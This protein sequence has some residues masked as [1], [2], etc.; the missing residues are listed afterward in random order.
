MTTK[1]ADG[2]LLSDD[3]AF[4]YFSTERFI[5]D[6]CNGSCCFICG[7][8]PNLKQFN[9]EHV[10]PR[11]LLK[12]YQLFERSIALPNGTNFRYRSYTV[13]CCR[14]CN[15][16]MGRDIEEPIRRILNGSLESLIE[17]IEREGVR[18]LF[19]WLCLI[20]IK[21]HLKS[22]TLPVERDRRKE[23]SLIG[24]QYDWTLLHHIHCVARSFYTRA[25][26]DQNVFGSLLIFQAKTGSSYEPFDYYDIYGANSILVRVGNFSLVS[27]LDDAGGSLDMFR[28]HIDIINGPL[29]PI[30]LREILA[31]LSYINLHI[32]ERPA[33]FTELRKP[34]RIRARVPV[35]EL[36]DLDK[37]HRGQLLDACCG[38]M[39][40]NFTNSNI[41]EVKLHLLQGTHTFLRNEYGDFD[42]RSMEPIE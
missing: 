8:S 36:D 7:S 32:K 13:P 9:N 35:V 40:E 15:T 39:L 4:L 21:T 22:R 10:L 29:S 6:I 11:W 17:H 12:K 31:H 23:S 2:S 38:P 5:R 37:A 25:S 18:L 27:V 34:P 20:F 33:F 19:I 28:N 16:M 30:Q 42:A 41:E 24:D 14:E 26:I 3:G 1:T